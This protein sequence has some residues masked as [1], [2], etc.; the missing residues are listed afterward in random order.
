MKKSSNLI[1][2]CT[3]LFCTIIFFSLNSCSKED[4]D[5]KTEPISLST[6]KSQYAPHEIV[7]ITAG[8]NIFSASSQIA[9]I[10]GVDVE[11]ATDGNNAAFV[12]P[13]LENGTYNLTFSLGNNSYDVPIEVVALTSMTSVDNYFSEMQS[14]MN[15]NISDL[16]SHILEL[17]TREG[18]TTEVQALQN[19]LVFY[20]NQLDSYT[21]QYNSL[22][23]ED[24]I[25]FAKT[26]A[27]NQGTLDEY[28]ALT[29]DFNQSASALRT[30]QTVQDYETQV[31]I[32]KGKFVASVIYT[33]GHIPFILAGGKVAAV[34]AGNPGVLLALGVVVTS[35]MVNVINTATMA[36]TL[37][38]KSLKPYE[39]IMESG[40]KIF[41]TGVETVEN[42]QARYR[43]LIN[44]DGGNA[45]ISNIVDTY[46]S[47]MEKYN[48]FRNSLPSIFRPSYAIPSLKNTFTSTTRSVYNQYINITNVSNPNI[49]LQKIP[50]SDGS[51]KL[52][53]TT[54]ETTDQIFTYD[55]EYSNGNFTSNLK[56]SVS[57]KVTVNSCNLS[58]ILGTWKVELYNTCYPNPDGTPAY[59]TQNYTLDLYADGSAV[60]TYYDGSKETG[61]Y[62]AYYIGNGCRITTSGAP[63]WCS[64]SFYT[65]SSSN[66]QQFSICGCLSMKHTKL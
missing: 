37:T 58:E 5:T 15:D 53:A 10:N 3:F 64:P 4:E 9:K 17:Q 54:N 24:K 2:Y 50:Q 23:N 6:E 12:L 49:T 18:N 40:Q 28:N 47:L 33:V 20:Q 45:T 38:I 16:S 32:S 44:S 34:S 66:Y 43:S 39:F 52:K 61:T 30:T 21:S 42:A 62:S 51:L 25:M 8:E 55:V 35:F 22:S 13:S 57:A 29:A 19:D 11:L 56:K 63:S 27:A 60:F 31:E 36:Q 48:N 14:S 41:Q 26:I 46:N 7:T 59:D 1:I 65:S